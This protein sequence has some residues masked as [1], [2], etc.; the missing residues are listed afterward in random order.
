[1]AKRKE[2]VPDNQT[3]KWKKVEICAMQKYG[4]YFI[5][6]KRVTQYFGV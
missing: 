3:R 2:Y 4:T 1:M 5:I 6:I